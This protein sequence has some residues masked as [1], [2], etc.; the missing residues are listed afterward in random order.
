MFVT[1]NKVSGD[2]ILY[3]LQN[4]WLLSKNEWQLENP[5]NQSIALNSILHKIA[6]AEK[7][8]FFD[9][10]KTD[11]DKP[12]AILGFFNIGVKLYETFFIASNLM[13]SYGMKVSYELR[14]VLKDKEETDYRGCTCRLYSESDHPNQ[15]K[16]F[17]FIGFDYIPE[18]SIGNH[19]YFEYVSDLK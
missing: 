10:W 19:K 3:I 2:E 16:W 8:G 6:Q 7:D 14:K 11:N 4:P 5:S 9:I 1:H 15:I 13:E 18:K 12:I 17:K